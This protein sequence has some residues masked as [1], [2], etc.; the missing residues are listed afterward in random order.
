MEHFI[1]LCSCWL[2]LWAASIDLKM[3][4]TFWCFKPNPF[5]QIKKKHSV[6]NGHITVLSQAYY[7]SPHFQH[8]DFLQYA[9]VIWNWRFLQSWHFPHFKKIPSV[10]PHDLQYS[11]G[12]EEGKLGLFHE[13]K[14]LW[15]DPHECTCAL[16]HVR[17]VLC[18]LT[19]PRS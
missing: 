15:I 2:L 6:Y 9:Y 16:S 4:K 1:S 10:L 17:E 7:R 19:A 14:V 12:W 8:L 3:F 5:S 18:T 13:R 11:V